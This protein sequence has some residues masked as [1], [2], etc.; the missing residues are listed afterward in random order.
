MVIGCSREGTVCKGLSPLPA[1]LLLFF[2]NAKPSECSK[3]VK[4]VALKSKGVS[5]APP[6]GRSDDSGARVGDAYVTIFTGDWER[7][8][9]WITWGDS[10]SMMF[11]K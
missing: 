7:K 2:L 8:A 9:S 5:L 3:D 6:T 10:A 11:R 4:C 1:L